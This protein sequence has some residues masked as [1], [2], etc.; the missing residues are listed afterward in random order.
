MSDVVNGDVNINDDDFRGVWST[1]QPTARQRRRI[2]GRV[3]E[4]LEASDTSLA[5]EWLGLFRIEPFSAAGLVT[6]SAVAIAI[7]IVTAPPL[8]WLA[9]VLM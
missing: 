2:D 3:F 5:A 8:V 7:S 1:L 6:V 9:Q 4:W